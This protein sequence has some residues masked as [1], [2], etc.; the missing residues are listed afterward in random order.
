MTRKYELWCHQWHTT[1]SRSSPVSQLLVRCTR[2]AWI[3]T[4]AGTVR[5]F[6]SIMRRHTDNI[7]RVRT[8]VSRRIITQVSPCH[9]KVSL[10]FRF[11]SIS[12]STTTTLTLHFHFPR[13]IP[14]N[15]PRVNLV[16]WFESDLDTW[17]WR[18]QPTGGWV[19]HWFLAVFYA[20][21]RSCPLARV[22]S[23]F[24]IM[25]MVRQSISG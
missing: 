13:S 6:P 4:I 5:R 14:R 10:F 20:M 24:S 7:V 22:S 8:G 21:P 16:L 25:T 17:Q 12:A 2:R 18:A 3:A 19:R 23:T 15:M 1:T 11:A 9:P